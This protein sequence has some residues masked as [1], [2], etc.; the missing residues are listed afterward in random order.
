MENLAT[1][2]KATTDNLKA[3]NADTAKKFSKSVMEMQATLNNIFNELSKLNT[4]IERSVSKSDPNLRNVPNM[5][6]ENFK[7]SNQFKSKN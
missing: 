7:S 5:Q 1:M 2:Q 3:L 4:A 6:E